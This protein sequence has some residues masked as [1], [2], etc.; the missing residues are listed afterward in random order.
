MLLI[1]E[2]V[3][4]QGSTRHNV[5]SQVQTLPEVLDRANLEPD[6]AIDCFA[7]SER[8]VCALESVDVSVR[9]L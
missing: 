8:H 9:P 5:A 2:S 4:F 3:H 6:K 7:I 1:E